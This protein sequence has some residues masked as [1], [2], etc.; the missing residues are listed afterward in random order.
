LN[1]FDRLLLSNAILNNSST[2]AYRVFIDDAAGTNNV[3]VGAVVS[4]VLNEV[5]GKALDV[6][7]HPW[8][9]QGNS[10]IRSVTVPLPS[11]NISETFAWAGPQD[12]SLVNW[13]PQQFSWD[14]STIILGTL[15]SYAPTYSALLQGIVGV[16]ATQ[17]PP[18]FGDA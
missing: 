1:G 9:P 15:C 4:T 3:R 10:M 11:S 14:S 2:N 5:T 18:S 7:V 12:Y 8:M 16:G 6:L 17:S 13:A